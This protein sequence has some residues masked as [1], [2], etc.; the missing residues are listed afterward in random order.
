M[1]R[2]AGS[3]RRIRPTGP[4]PVPATPAENLHSMRTKLRTLHDLRLRMICN[5][6]FDKA[7]L[8]SEEIERQKGFVYGQ[9]AKMTDTEIAEA[10][11]MDYC[12]DPEAA[13]LSQPIDTVPTCAGCGALLESADAGC[14]QC[15]PY[16]FD[17]HE[18]SNEA[19]LGLAI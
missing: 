3:N 12:T 4:K 18:I 2:H 14:E 17:A 5:D 15:N 10:D 19:L 9:C 16:E 13:L 11:A 8:V 6:E 1:Y 7:E